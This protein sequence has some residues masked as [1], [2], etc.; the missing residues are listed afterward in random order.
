MRMT[1]HFNVARGTFHLHLVRV[2]PTRAPIGT[3]N[4]PPRARPRARN[5]AASWSF[6]AREVPRPTAASARRSDADSAAMVVGSDCT[7]TLEL[8]LASLQNFLVW[9]N[10]LCVGSSGGAW[11]RIY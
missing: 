9:S 2:R 4:P 3:R 1:P 11:Q 5:L 8:R 7:F 6:V 10:G